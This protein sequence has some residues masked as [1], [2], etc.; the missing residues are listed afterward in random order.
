MRRP[1]SIPSRQRS[2]HI[3]L[4][5]CR[6]RTRPMAIVGP[7]GRGERTRGSSTS[8]VPRSLWIHRWRRTLLPCA[9]VPQLSSHGIELQPRD[10]TCIQNRTCPHCRSAVCVPTI[11][12]LCRSRRSPVNVFCASR[13]RV[14]ARCGGRGRRTQP[15][16]RRRGGRAGKDTR[17]VFVGRRSWRSPNLGGAV[18]AQCWCSLIISGGAAACASERADAVTPQRR[19]SLDKACG[20]ESG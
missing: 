10:R 5:L 6:S 19:F 11:Y 16:S 3:A 8:N 9:A 13:R 15:A 20:R 7:L 4:P 2:G 17:G 18:T 12:G 14:G 1:A